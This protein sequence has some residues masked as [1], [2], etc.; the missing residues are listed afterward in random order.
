MQDTYLVIIAAGLITLV[1]VSLAGYAM[2]GSTETSVLPEDS[3]EIK[4]RG[5]P[6][7]PA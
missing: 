1:L 2:K 4:L 7:G 6:N 5:G 3:M